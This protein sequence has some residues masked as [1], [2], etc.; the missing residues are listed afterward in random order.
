MGNLINIKGISQ[1]DE[2]INSKF[3]NSACGPVTALVLL[4]YHF[5]NSC[6]YNVNQLYK[7]L[8]TSRIG[9]F[10]RP[11]IHAM[12]KLFG[13]NWVVE[14]CGIDEVKRQIDAGRPVAAKFDKWF[15]LRHRGEFDFDYHWVP[16]IGYEEI[17]DDLLLVIHDNGGINR[18]SQLRKISYS[19]N[20][21]ILSFIM[22]EPKIV[23]STIKN[24]C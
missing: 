6:T 12:R 7:L 22:V 8:K 17:S 13:T 10:K 16:V 9:A 5:P 19:K 11:F 18:A 20:K 24:H 23:K 3:R 15:S 14:K 1:H 21:S 4:E 2:A